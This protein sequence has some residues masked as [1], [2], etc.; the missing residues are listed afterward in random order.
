MSGKYK[1]GQI[2]YLIT[3]E[4][5]SPRMVTA[6]KFTI[7]GGILYTLTCG[8]QDSSHYEAEISKDKNIEVVLGIQNN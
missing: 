2:V 7:D 5:Q 1:L 6:I 4:A 8:I 3:D